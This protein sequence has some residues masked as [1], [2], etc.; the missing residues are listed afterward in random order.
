MCVLP[1]RAAESGPPRRSDRGIV[2]PM[3]SRA[4]DAPRPAGRRRP[5]SATP[6]AATTVAAT[7]VAGTAGHCQPVTTVATAAAVKAGRR[8]AAAVAVAA[9][10]CLGWL[11]LPA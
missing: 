2:R 5:A 4:T 11:T 6:L 3:P 7:T 10:A 9:V 1:G 8:L